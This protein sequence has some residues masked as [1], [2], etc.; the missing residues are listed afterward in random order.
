MAKSQIIKDLAN[1]IVDLHTSLKRAKVILQEIGNNDINDWINNEI[2]GYKN[3][4]DVPLYRKIR[5]TL[6][7]S[8]INGSLN[9]SNVAI[10]LNN[11]DDDIVE[12]FLVNSA[13]QSIFA[14]QQAI[15]SNQSFERKLTHQECVYLSKKTGYMVYDAYAQVDC[16]S[17]TDIISQVENKLLNILICLEREFGNLDAL[18]IDIDSKNE[19][20][21]KEITNHI[22]VMIYNDQSVIIGN[23]NEFKDSNVASYIKNES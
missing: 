21:L 12:G 13:K 14:L 4:E 2:E 20:E 17:I 18:D 15:S 7:G 19:Q 23:N 22:Y 6:R 8:F 3:V 1:S 16:S 10:P 5:G 9:E 11:V